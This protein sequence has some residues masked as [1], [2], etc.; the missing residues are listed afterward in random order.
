MVINGHRETGYQVDCSQYRDAPRHRREGLVV[1]LD[2][3]TAVRDGIAREGRG[4]A[5][6]WRAR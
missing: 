5:V 2:Y 4:P 6:V 1:E 3:E